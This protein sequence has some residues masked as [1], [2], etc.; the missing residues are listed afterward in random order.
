LRHVKDKAV[1]AALRAAL[2]NSFGFGGACAVLAMR[3][4]DAQPGSDALAPLLEIGEPSCGLPSEA[5]FVTGLLTLG[6]AGVLHGTD[7]TAWLDS[8]CGNYRAELP[9][10]PLDLLVMERSRRFDRLAALTTLGCSYLMEDSGLAG[11]HR[12][13]ALPADDSSN[14]FREPVGLVL[15]NALGS[16]GRSAEFV[17]RILKRGARGANPAEFP[18]LLPSAVTGNASIYAQLRGPTFNVSDMGSTI[19]SAMDLGISCIRGR[20]ARAMLAGTTECRDDAIVAAQQQGAALG[21]YPADANDGSAWLLLEGQSAARERGATGCELAT[22]GWLGELLAASRRPPSPASDSLVL[23]ALDQEAAAEEVLSCLGWTGTAIR[24]C[25][26]QPYDG[27]S[28]PGFV[29]AA[30]AALVCAG[31]CSSTLVVTPSPRGIH[32]AVFRRTP[33]LALKLG[34]GR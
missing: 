22:A 23:W 13:E 28:Q 27:W 17:Q 12:S 3:H 1:P 8:D 4:R 30:G 15:G 18:H 34:R 11:A 10:S 20:L 2:S 14:G 21:R 5:I 33:L 26:P 25:K 32:C 19:Q 9:F 29:L 16:V 6:A 24:S 31:A 7:N